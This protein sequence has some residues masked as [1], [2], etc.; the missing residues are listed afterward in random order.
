MKKFVKNEQG[1]CPVCGGF[2]LDFE[3]AEI[4]DNA[5][6]YPWTCDDCGATGDEFYD[7]TFS[8][9]WNVTDKNGEEYSPDG[10]EQK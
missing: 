1:N 4:D 8:A 10:N 9:H 5:V 6:K 2:N 7:M 3:S